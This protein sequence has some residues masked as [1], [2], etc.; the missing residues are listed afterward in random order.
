MID[1][2]LIYGIFF[3]LGLCIIGIAFVADVIG[4][5]LEG[6]INGVGDVF[7]SAAHIEFGDVS[8]RGMG[9]FSLGIFFMAFGG[10]GAML[11]IYNPDAN[12]LLS[13]PMALLLS[14]IL[15]AV[16]TAIMIQVF[17][18]SPDD[19]RPMTYWMGKEGTITVGTD[20]KEDLGEISFPEG[21]HM[22]FIVISDVPLLKG[23]TA[24]VTEVNGNRLRVKQK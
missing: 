14:S 12:P 24:V 10:I 2:L 9:T 21:R 22:T 5:G 16:L 15:T 11:Y 8:L 6:V 19:I 13:A 23:D 4:D 3:A 20:G 1:M 17:A 7:E 18:N